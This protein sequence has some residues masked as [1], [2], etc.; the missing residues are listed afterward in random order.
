MKHIH[1]GNLSFV[2]LGDRDYVNGLTI[3]EEGLKAFMAVDRSEISRPIFIKQFIV[4]RFLRTN[5]RVDILLA[6]PGEK[7]PS[8]PLI[9]KA[10]ARIDLQTKD[11]EFCL[12]LTEICDGHVPE[13][14]VAYDRGAYI[15]EQHTLADGTT[16]A[17]LTN[18]VGVFDLMR[19]II[20]VNQRITNVEL[21]KMTG[22]K[23]SYLAYVKNFRYIEDA[24]LSEISGIT[25]EKA[26][27]VK[28]RGNTFAVRNVRIHLVN[29]FMSEICYYV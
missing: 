18:L 8:H 1:G 22:K 10:N 2:F 28:T 26:T 16:F 3:F 9:K 20:E 29:S 13:N 23:K 27:I 21:E 19:G 11:S 15:T 14:I 24:E 12:L 5:G 7:N 17:K 25:C 6:E 4:N